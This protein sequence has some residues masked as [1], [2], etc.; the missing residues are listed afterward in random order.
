[1][2]R[3]PDSERLHTASDEDVW[4]KELHADD[5][6]EV[7]VRENP[8]RKQHLSL[9]HTH[10]HAHTHTTLLHVCASEFGLS[11]RWQSCIYAFVCIVYACAGYSMCMHMHV[12]CVH[13]CARTCVRWLPNVESRKRKRLNGWRGCLFIHYP[14]A[15]CGFR[16]T[17]QH[18]SWAL[19]RWSVCGPASALPKPSALSFLALF[20]ILSV[21]CCLQ[22]C[23]LLFLAS[24][25]LTCPSLLKLGPL[26]DVV[27]A[28]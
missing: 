7:R 21:L 13:V 9:P 14:A 8:E 12:Q 10:E 26:S 1:M 24:F 22:F 11:G 25:S 4:A 27:F 23:A 17:W 28:H 19:Q 6:Y 5:R 15:F 20:S 18:L 16:G 2:P 3:L